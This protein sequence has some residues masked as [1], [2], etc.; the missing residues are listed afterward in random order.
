MGKTKIPQPKTSFK[1]IKGMNKI[2]SRVLGKST[3]TN[4]II[5]L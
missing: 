1:I 2:E 3:C 4:H 5:S